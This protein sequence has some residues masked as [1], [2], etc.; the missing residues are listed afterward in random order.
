MWGFWGGKVNRKAGCMLRLYVLNKKYLELLRRETE[1][2][3]WECDNH[4]WKSKLHCKYFTAAIIYRGTPGDK[5]PSYYIR[6]NA[7]YMKAVN[8]LTGASLYGW[9]SRALSGEKGVPDWVWSLIYSLET[10]I[11]EKC[12]REGKNFSV[13]PTDVIITQAWK[14]K[15]QK[16]LNVEQ[17]EYVLGLG[18]GATIEDVTATMRLMGI[19]S[20]KEQEAQFLNFDRNARWTILRRQGKTYREIG[21]IWAKENPDDFRSDLE[22]YNQKHNYNPEI[23]KDQYLKH[24]YPKT[25]ERAVNRFEKKIAEAFP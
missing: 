10:D 20:H 11:Q 19:K 4:G 5:P 14:A 23:T 7:E 22:N 15:E 3:N 17:Y 1:D 12:K 6:K 21:E 8:D 24:V 9:V 25:I 2:S 13:E 18:S 16:Y